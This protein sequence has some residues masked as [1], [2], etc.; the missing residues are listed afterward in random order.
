[1]LFGNFLNPF[2]DSAIVPLIGLGTLLDCCFFGVL[3]ETNSGDKSLHW[4][5]SSFK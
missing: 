3:K 2:F 1:M 4:L 5:R